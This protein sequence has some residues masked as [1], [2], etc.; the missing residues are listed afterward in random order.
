MAYFTEVQEESLQVRVI[1]LPT[2]VPPRDCNREK[3]ILRVWVGV[4]P[5]G[6]GTTGGRYWGGGGDTTGGT[7]LGDSTGGTLLRGHYWGT[8]LGGHY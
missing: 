7:L 5:L 4:A 3:H 1:S 6:G 2:S 8:L